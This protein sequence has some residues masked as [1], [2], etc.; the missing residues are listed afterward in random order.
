MTSTILSTDIPWLEA[1]PASGIVGKN[2]IQTVTILFDTT[3]LPLGTYSS[4]IAILSNDEDTPVIFVP[5]T[6]T[7]IPHKVY[8]PLL[9]R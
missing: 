3:D 7:V 4:T 9:L 2:G 6:L 8:L 5:I 1:H